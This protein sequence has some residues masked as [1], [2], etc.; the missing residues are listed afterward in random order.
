MTQHNEL[1]CQIIC[2]DNHFDL[3]LFV[4]ILAQLSANVQRGTI[5]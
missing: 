3:L 4:I 5:K 1:L 2:L